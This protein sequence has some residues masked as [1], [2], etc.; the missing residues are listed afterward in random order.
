MREGVTC[1]H[2]VATAVSCSASQRRTRASSSSN[3]C[4]QRPRCSGRTLQTISPVEKRASWRRGS[5]ASCPS[6]H[7]SR[8][9]ERRAWQIASSARG[10]DV[11]R[12]N[13]SVMSGEG[14]AR[15]VEDRS[16]PGAAGIPS[17]TGTKRTVAIM[18]DGRA[19]VMP[20]GKRSTS[21]WRAAVCGLGAA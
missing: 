3:F 14:A 16:I 19:K 5:S 6:V 8:S 9:M 20:G 4:R 15:A 12:L 1:R 18:E 17:R 7:S 11:S 10:S 13:R 21:D 2:Y